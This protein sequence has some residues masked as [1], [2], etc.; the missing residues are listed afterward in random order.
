MGAAVGYAASLCKKYNITPREL[1]L[2]H[3]EEYMKL[4]LSSNDK[5]D[6]P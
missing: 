4:I 6:N 5:E 1:Y 2:D 3:L